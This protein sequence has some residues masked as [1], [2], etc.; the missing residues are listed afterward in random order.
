MFMRKFFICALLFTLTVHWRL[1][2]AET[3]NLGKPIDLRRF[4]AQIA[5]ILR[6]E[7]VWEP[8]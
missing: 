8:R 3:P 2:L 5:R 1:A 4:P 6:G 7:A